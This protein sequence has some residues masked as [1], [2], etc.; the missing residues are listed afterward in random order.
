MDLTAVPVAVLIVSV[1]A[2]LRPLALERRVMLAAAPVDASLTG[3]T[4][5]HF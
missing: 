1:V 4:N 2:L 5:G 3:G